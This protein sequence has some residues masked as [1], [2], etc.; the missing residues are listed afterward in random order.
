LAEAANEPFGIYVHWPFCLSKCPYC[1]FNS[2]V[3]TAID[4]GDWRQALLAELDHFAEQTGGREVTSVFFGGGTPSLMEPATVAAVLGRIAQKWRLPDGAEITLEANP[5]AVDAERFL[6]FKAAGVNRLSLGVQAL[7]DTALKFLGRRHDQQEAL[8]ALDL[9]QANFPRVSFDLI[10]ARPGQTAAQWEAELSRALT[11]GTSHLSL[12]QLTIEEQT[13]FA[14]AYRRGDFALPPDDDAAELFALTRA[15]C[16]AAGLPAYEVSNHAAPGQQSRHNLLYWQGGEWLGIGPGAHG[17]LHSPSGTRAIRQFRAPVRWLETVAAQGHGT[18]EESPVAH[19]DYE[20][21]LVM[22]G[23]RLD[24]GVSA[25]RFAHLAGRPLDQALDPFGLRTLVEFGM[26]EW[27]DD[28]LRATDS[29]MPI[30]NSLLAR[31]LS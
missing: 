8:R 29:G 21:E 3:A 26:V 25:A 9:A 23:L 17:R 11:F 5:G 16:A 13:P 22:M 14:G 19:A 6:G 12:Y 2:H 30:L 7:D 10:Y 28:H 20:T 27:R 1:D 18:E 31:L 4:H 15:L 24:S